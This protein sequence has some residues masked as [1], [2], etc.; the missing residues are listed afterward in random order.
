MPEDQYLRYQ[1]SPINHFFEVS[2]QTI[3]IHK[4]VDGTSIRLKL[5]AQ[6][7]MFDT[8][9]IDS[10]TP[11][12][13]TATD[14]SPLRAKIEPGPAMMP[15]D[16]HEGFAF[17]SSFVERFTPHSGHDCWRGSLFL[18]RQRLLAGSLSCHGGGRWGPARCRAVPCN[19]TFK[20]LGCGAAEQ[21]KHRAT[22]ATAAAPPAPARC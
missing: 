8:L 3:R 4:K 21:A 13:T 11:S 9:D 17:M 18:S 15:P 22:T 20:A 1:A 5:Q 10:A 7:R 6:Q 2:R 19:A 12:V 14:T 16:T